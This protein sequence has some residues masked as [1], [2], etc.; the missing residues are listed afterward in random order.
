M[1][2]GPPPQSRR[3]ASP[4]SCLG[5]YG[6]FRELPFLADWSSRPAASKDA[7]AAL[8]ASPADSKRSRALRTLPKASS[9]SPASRRYQP[10]GGVFG[11]F[12][13][14]LRFGKFRLQRFYG[15]RDQI[16]F[17][18]FIPLIGGD[19]AEFHQAFGFKL[20]VLTGRAGLLKEIPRRIVVALF[21]RQMRHAQQDFRRVMPSAAL[22][23]MPAAAE[24]TRPPF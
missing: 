21:H 8:N 4:L 23:S 10:S 13:L 5:L 6:T 2:D 14:R 16:L 9:S 3:R 17:L 1:R 12:H 7:F 24:R 18:G 20:A 19:T 22:E 15:L 11:P